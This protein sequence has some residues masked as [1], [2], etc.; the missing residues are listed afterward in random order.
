MQTFIIRPKDQEQE[1]ALQTF[2]EESHIPYEQV[3]EMDETEQTLANQIMA[4][5]LSNIIQDIE[6][7]KV[8]SVNL[9][10]LWK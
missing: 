3:P 10:D 9:E 4:K 1:K 2:L 6:Q 7:G 8:T 5:K